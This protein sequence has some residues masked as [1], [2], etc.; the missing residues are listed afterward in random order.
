M[1]DCEVVANI[2]YEFGPFDYGGVAEIAELL[3]VS[4][5]TVVNWRRAC[6]DFPD[7]V[8]SLAMGPVYSLCAVRDWRRAQETSDD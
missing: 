3:G 6:S 2:R 8:A 4:K 5:Q 1:R 7:P